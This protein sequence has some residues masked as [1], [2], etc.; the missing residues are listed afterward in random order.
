MAR[1]LTMSP[2]LAASTWLL[3]A[4]V[5]ALAILSPS[6]AVAG[7]APRVAVAVAG[8]G[9]DELRAAVVAR[10]RRHC[11][12]VPASSEAWPKAVRRQ[13]L[14]AFIDG[15]VF[16]GASWRV[17]LVVRNGHSARPAG[18]FSWSS[19]D[20]GEL[21]QDV[22]REAPGK[23]MA[24]VSRSAPPPALR[25][26]RPTL[27]GEPVAISADSQTEAEAAAEDA[28]DADPAP[29]A[30]PG[31]RA[32][33]AS[34][35]WLEVSVGPA[36]IGRALSLTDNPSGAPGYSLP[37]SAAFGGE[38]LALPLAVPLPWWPASSGAP[39]GAVGVAA[40]VETSLG[41]ET[42]AN[43]PG[44]AGH[45]TRFLSYRAGVRGR[46]LFS[47]AA[48]LLGL[49]YGEQHFDVDLP[50][51]VVSPAATYRFWR[52]S[53]GGRL[54]LDDLRL[55]L[56]MAY[57]GLLSLEGWGDA[58]RFPR[59]RVRGLEGG[60]RLGYALSDPLEVELGAE[61]RRFAFSMNA[62]AGDPVVVGGALDEYF[63][64]ALRLVWRLR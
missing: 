37:A 55:S 1:S 53:L 20:P 25:R 50:S 18:T 21:M 10:M 33:N 57:L 41:A 34:A 9:G 29:E 17:K 4:F 36:M 58:E 2:R 12:I 6:P 59:A 35:P 16:A 63:S 43:Q 5:P 14:A 49:D 7:P 54:T 31:R 28:I 56:S 23:L 11:Q 26:P 30:A 51:E 40:A 27:R 47:N 60:V 15:R 45:A 48:L 3:L 46:L 13:R 8:P 44:E 19:S 24:I 42:A 62:R 22:L 61:M 52:P 39:A 32:G 38:V 64:V